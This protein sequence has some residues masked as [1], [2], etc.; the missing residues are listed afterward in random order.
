[1]GQNEDDVKPT[2]LALESALKAHP[3]GPLVPN[4]R[5][6]SP[7]DPIDFL[8]HRLTYKFGK[9]LIEP[10]PA[11]LN[12]FEKKLTSGLSAVLCKTT[13]TAVRRA[14]VKRLRTFVVQWVAAFKTVVE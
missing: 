8:G 6:F 9:V 4:E 11:K 12:E 3:A 7:G 14:K 10:S 2:Q 5:K 13:P 1:M